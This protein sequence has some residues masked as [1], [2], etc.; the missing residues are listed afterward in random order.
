MGRLL[1]LVIGLALVALGAYWMVTRLAG[2][3][4]TTPDGPSAPKAVLDDA[5]AKAKRIEEDAQRR[6]DEALRRTDE[7]R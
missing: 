3:V 5:R 4:A 1:S 2:S 7:G 6:A